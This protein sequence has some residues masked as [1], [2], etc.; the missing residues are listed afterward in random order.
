MTTKIREWGL[1]NAWLDQLASIIA[2]VSAAYIVA[3][4]PTG[5]LLVFNMAATTIAALVMAAATFACALAYQSDS[6]LLIQARLRHA[7][8]L[9]RNWRAIIAGSFLASV[10]PAIGLLTPATLG[11]AAGVYGLGLAACCFWR[12]LFWLSYTL[13]GQAADDLRPTVRVRQNI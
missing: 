5:T 7:E 3:T 12:A 10:L 2:A 6:T 9:R 4:P 8:T 1:R 11:F 13:F